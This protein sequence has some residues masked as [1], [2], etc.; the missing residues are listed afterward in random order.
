M[1]PHVGSNPTPSA[2]LVRRGVRVAEGARLE[3][4]YTS[5]RRVEGSNPSLSASGPG[6]RGRAPIPAPPGRDRTARHS[7]G[8][9]GFEDRGFSVAVLDGE[10]AVP[11]TR[12]PL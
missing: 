4:V 3:I 2:I 8:S 10:V 6:G 11:C 7:S 1:S 5:K 9:P 12:N